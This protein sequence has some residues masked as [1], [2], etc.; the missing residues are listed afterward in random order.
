MRWVHQRGADD[1]DAMTDLAK[2]FRARLSESATVR[3][4]SVIRDHVS[5]DGTRKWLLDVGVGNAVEAV[6][7]PETDRG[8][9]C[10]ST[11]AGCAVNCRFCSTG[12]QGFSRNLAVSEIVGQ[13]WLA[14]RALGAH[15]PPAAG[16]GDGAGPARRPITQR[17]LHGHG[18]TVAELRRDAGFAAPDAR[19]QRLWAVATARHR[20]HFGRGADDRPPSRGL[21]G[22]ARGLAARAERCAA[23]R[24]WCR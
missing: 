22:R 4:P 11:Q 20:L 14:N 12:K 16:D 15:S 3:A 17:G 19:R 18:R 7:I 1:F 24:R 5:R 8:T 13:L 6:F 2:A 23:R 10:V 9:L 21:P